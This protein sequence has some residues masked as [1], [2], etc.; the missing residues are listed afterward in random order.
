MSTK[1]QIKD[2]SL[3]DLSPERI[4]IRDSVEDLTITESPNLK[5][6]QFS[7][8]SK[9]KNI[10]LSDTGVTSLKLPHFV[11]R[12]ENGDLPDSLKTITITSE[13]PP[14]VDKGSIPKTIEKIY[15]PAKSLKVYEDAWYNYEFTFKDQLTAIPE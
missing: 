9:L 7:P 14:E 11:S 4:S 1:I 6:I 13:K 8:N 15:V 10:D 5:E 2:Y 3:N 12:I